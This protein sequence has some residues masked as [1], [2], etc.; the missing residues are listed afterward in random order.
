LFVASRIIHGESV[1]LVEFPPAPISEASFAVNQECFAPEHLDDDASFT[2]LLGDGMHPPVS[3]ASFDT[4][5]T[6][7]VIDAI[8]QTLRDS[9]L[10]INRILPVG[11][12][13]LNSGSLAFAH[14]DI[15]QCLSEEEALECIEKCGFEI[16]ST[17]RRRI[18]YMQSPH[19][20]HWRHESVLSFCARKMRTVEETRHFR[21]LPEWLLDTSAAIPVRSEFSEASSENQLRAQILAAIDGKRSI[22][23]IGTM[24]ASEYGLRKAEAKNAARRILMS[25]YESPLMNAAASHDDLS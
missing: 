19:S 14:N 3:D 18:P 20:A 11:G 10:A 22:D 5:L 13:W 7:W 16:L 4:V 2:F 1:T 21:H 17:D 6:P 12:K 24:L 9:A 23:E 25:L 15:A 8:P